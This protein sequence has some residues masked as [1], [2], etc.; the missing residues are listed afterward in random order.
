MCEAMHHRKGV[1]P[2]IQVLDSQVL[3]LD[4][5]TQDRQR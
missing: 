4:A 3:F 2:Q 5:G 1:H